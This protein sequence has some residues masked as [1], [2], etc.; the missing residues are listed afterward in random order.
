MTELSSNGL[1]RYD[2]LIYQFIVKLN[3]QIDKLVQPTLSMQTQINNNKNK[4]NLW[5]KE[6]CAKPIR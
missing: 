3:R 6:S 2:T 4:L 1:V 5:I